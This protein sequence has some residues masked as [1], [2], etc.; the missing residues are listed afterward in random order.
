MLVWYLDTA[1]AADRVLSPGRYL[2]PRDE[3][4]E[5]AEPAFAPHACALAWFEAERANLG[6]ATYQAADCGLDVLAWQLPNALFGFFDLPPY[7][8][9]WVGALT[10]GLTP[11]RV[12]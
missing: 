12:A 3:A 9:D 2:L 10:V 8:A 4:G 5:R 7:W 1:R 6:A 11:P